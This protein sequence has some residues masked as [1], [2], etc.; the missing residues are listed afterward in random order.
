MR[1]GRVNHRFAGRFHAHIGGYDQC[2][3]TE[4]ATTE[5]DLF[6]LCGIAR[7]HRN[8]RALSGELCG[9]LGANSV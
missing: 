9:Q 5:R 7:G 1:N 6:K 4:R 8:T 2:V 3:G